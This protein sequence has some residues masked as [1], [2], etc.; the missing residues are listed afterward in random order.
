MA[1]ITLKNLP[2]EVH[3]RLKAR[4]HKRQRSLNSEAISCLTAAVMTA[5]IDS[6]AMLARARQLRSQVKGYL[7]DGHVRH[8]KSAGRL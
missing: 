2:R 6:E 8:A 5:P 4:A 7:T 3:R 1:T